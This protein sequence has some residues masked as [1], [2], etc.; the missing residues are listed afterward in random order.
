[1]LRAYFLPLAPSAN[2]PR[3]VFFLLTHPNFLPL[4]PLNNASPYAAFFP[5]FFFPLESRVTSVIPA[6]SHL[7]LSMVSI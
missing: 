1:M 7:Y 6:R 4:A 5:A 3:S 2:L